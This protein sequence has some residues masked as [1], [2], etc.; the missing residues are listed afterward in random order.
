MPTNLTPDDADLPIPPAYDI[1][2][3]LDNLIRQHLSIKQY[4][5]Q[6]LP[7]PNQ[8]TR[9]YLDNQLPVSGENKPQS[10]II[11]FHS[12]SQEHWKML[13]LPSLLLVVGCSF[14]IFTLLLVKSGLVTPEEVRELVLAAVKHFIGKS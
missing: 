11:N 8:W 9:V 6:D 14:M 13:L 3:K 4:Q 1:D 10:I 5:Q 12:P 2:S 7:P